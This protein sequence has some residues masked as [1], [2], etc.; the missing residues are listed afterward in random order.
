MPQFADVILPLPLQSAFTYALP[1]EMAQQTQVG[2]RVIVPFGNRKFYTAIVVRL[3]DEKPPYPTKPI[4]ELLDA[5]PIILPEQLRL[6]KWLADYYLCTLGDVFKAALPSGLKLESE[7]SIL[8]NED[9]EAESPLSPNEE[10]IWRALGIKA[11]QTLLSLQ[12]ETGIKSILPAVKSLLEKGG[13][14]MK[15]EI[16]R[17]YKPKT[18]TCVRLAEAYHD[19]ARLHEAFDSLHRSPRQEAL[20]ACFLEL[21]T[22]IEKQKLLQ[23]ANCSDAILRELCQKGILETYAKPVERAKPAYQE[24]GASPL[25]PAQQK[26]MESIEEQW[27]KHNVCLLH[28]VTSSG[29]T[30]IY[31]HLMQKAIERQTLRHRGWCTQQPLPSFPEPGPSHHRRRA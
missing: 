23:E 11:E 18:V 1:P 28:G 31:I 3:H 10:K 25:T 20:L 22:P 16:R 26:A 7:S 15:E 9:W 21:E 17:T 2:S 19:E 29:K 14:R 30:E 27:K 13:V 5:N 8:L 24:A 12:K 6:W 4:S